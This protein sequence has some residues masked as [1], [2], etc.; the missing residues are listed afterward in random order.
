MAKW[1]HQIF[2]SMCFIYTTLENPF[3]SVNFLKMTQ[4]QPSFNHSLVCL[5]FKSSSLLAWQPVHVLIFRQTPG[6]SSW[7]VSDR[8]GITP[9]TLWLSHNWWCSIKYL[10]HWS[11]GRSWLTSKTVQ[12]KPPHHHRDTKWCR[13]EVRTR[14]LSMSWM[15]VQ[16]QLAETH[17]KI[18][19]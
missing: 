18:N 12:H 16:R 1:L 9:T 5:T 19:N 13:A 7:E 3:K 17:L 14:I 15:S 8:R 6:L 2:I 4:I 11:Y 10:F